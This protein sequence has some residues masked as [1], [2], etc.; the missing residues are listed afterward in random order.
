MKM[1]LWRNIVVHA[2]AGQGAADVVNKS[3]QVAQAFGGRVTLFDAVD[4]AT[5]DLLFEL[6]T[7]RGD[8]V[9]EFAATLRTEQL[10]TEIASLEIGVP[11]DVLV[12]RG[13]PGRALVGY[14]LSN[15]ADLIVKAVSAPDLQQMT[16]AGLTAL[17]LLRKTPIPTWFCA[18]SERRVRCVVAAVNL[19]PANEPRR[20]LNERVVVA[21][22]R[23]AALE[24]AELHVV[25]VADAARDR[26][27]EGIL[28]GAQYRRYLVEDRRGLR[29]GLT[30]LVA[31]LAPGAHLHLVQG[32]ALEALATKVSELGADLVAVGRDD[33]DPLA[34]VLARDFPERLLCRA[35]CSLLLVTP[36]W[37]PAPLARP[38]PDR[39]EASSCS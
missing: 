14:A 1:K 38:L 39:F 8:H 25:C 2:D 10:S 31:R 26:L 7:L 12:H 20:T 24:S 21:A 30:E 22:A 23:I 9:L 32:D 5:G 29:R 27:Y 17:H 19:A 6:P 34:G 3:V 28:S 33:A 13:I 11:I 4:S 15:D 35:S 18:P 37:A 16:S 36:E